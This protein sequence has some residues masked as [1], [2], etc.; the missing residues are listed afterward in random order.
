M[1]GQDAEIPATMDA[2]RVAANLHLYA[3]N[4]GIE[5]IV[6]R[7]SSALREPVWIADISGQRGLTSTQPAPSHLIHLVPLARPD[8]AQP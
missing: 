8:P 7:H 2:D 5:H 4:D 3:L 1:R 6:V